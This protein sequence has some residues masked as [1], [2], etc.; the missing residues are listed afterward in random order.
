MAT[1]ELILA[2]ALLGGTVDERLDPLPYPERSLARTA[3]ARVDDETTLIRRETGY[4]VPHIRNEKAADPFAAPPPAPTGAKGLQELRV[5]FVDENGSMPE[6][7]VF[8]V[9]GTTTTGVMPAVEFGD[10]PNPEAI[11]LAAAVDLPTIVTVEFTSDS[12][13]CTPQGFFPHRIWPTGDIEVVLEL[14]P[15]PTPTVRVLDE[16]GT[17]LPPGFTSFCKSRFCVLDGLRL[18]VGRPYE[19]GV[20]LQARPHTTAWTRLGAP[21]GPFEIR[22]DVERVVETIVRVDVAGGAI[23]RGLVELWRGDEL[24]AANEYLAPDIRIAAPPGDY[25]AR[26]VGFGGTLL[27]GTGQ[28]ALGPRTV[29]VEVDGLARNFSFDVPNGQLTLEGIPDGGVEVMLVAQDR[30]LAAIP[31]LRRGELLRLDDG[32]I[33]LRFRGAGLDDV[34]ASVVVGEQT[35][36]DLGA[37]AAPPTL[38]SGVVRDRAGE[39][40]P[41]APIYRWT[42]DGTAVS[43]FET[44][45]AGRFSVP[46]VRGATLTFGVREGADTVATHHRILDPHRAAELDV[47]QELL[48]FLAL[49]EAGPTGQ[50]LL[51]DGDERFQIVFVGESYTDINETYEDLNGNGVWDGTLFLDLDLD[52]LWQEDEPISYYGDRP[53]AT[54]ETNPSEGNEPFEDLNGDGYPNIDDFAVFERNARDFLRALLASPDVQR[55]GLDVE[56]FAIFVPSVQSGLDIDGLQE[57]DTR[58]GAEL[59]VGSEVLQVDFGAVGEVLNAEYPWRNLTVVLI[60]QPVRVG[61]ENSAVIAPAG[62]GHVSPN[63][64]APGRE[65]G[66]NPAGLQDESDGRRT[67]SLRTQFPG[68]HY[69]HHRDPELAP[70]AEG[71]AR[72]DT[73]IAVPGTR[74]LGLYAG[75]RLE[76]GGVYRSTSDS[77]MRNNALDFN[78]PSRDYFDLVLCG[79]LEGF[80]PAPAASGPIPDAEAASRLAA[81]IGCDLD[82]S[83]AWLDPEQPGHGFF[84]EHLARPNRI[85]AY[86]YTFLDGAPVWLVGTGT[87]LRNE[88][89]LEMLQPTGGAFPP[90]FDPAAVNRIPW[91]TVDLTFLPEGRARVAWDS[92]IEGF[93]AGSLDLARLARVPRVPQACRSGSYYDPT[94]DGHGVVV[95]VVRDAG[96]LEVFLAWY[97]FHDGEQVWL[98]GQGPLIDDR[99][100][101]ELEQF[102]GGDFPP[103]FS[104]DSVERQRWGTL[105]LAF[106]GDSG[107][108]MAWSAEQ[109]GFANGALSLVRLTELNGRRCLVQPEAR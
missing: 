102:T 8:E 28:F 77:R 91:G 57:R 65:L 49:D 69:T 71:I 17:E 18:R 25:Q 79:V 12:D 101:L 87:L 37:I 103:R 62:L 72:V 67:T 46:A 4:G 15:R 42:E 60:N 20:R 54:P 53:A 73:P 22:F 86:W 45:D 96:R 48:P 32:E 44:D 61:V 66:H 6:G 27:D 93:G 107:A 3:A 85:N 51:G 1:P 80:S 26:F 105:T 47:R 52:G 94:Q 76:S 50:R 34:S 21:S 90:N 92:A 31:Q 83:G 23:E 16:A 97:V 64:H 40:Q 41:N 55:L 19:V 29:D 33:E 89:R 68:R 43:R 75:A 9:S 100:E 95:E 109:P 14:E 35:T 38:L 82:M 74:G 24:M 106:E 10:G 56:A 70:W 84:I 13:E 88:A 2:A 63:S 11:V 30:P 104:S 7:C 78:E 108:E 36:L 99:V 98:V 81:R 59:D 5:T 58:F 39:P